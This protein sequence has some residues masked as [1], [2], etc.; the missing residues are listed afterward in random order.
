VHKT[1]SKSEHLKDTFQPRFML[2]RRTPSF[3]TNPDPYTPLPASG[4][5]QYLWGNIPTLDILRVGDNEDVVDAVN[6]S[7]KILFAA[8]GDLKNAIKT[9]VGLPEGYSGECVVVLNNM[10]FI[11]VARNAIMLLIAMHLD[12]RSQ[13]Q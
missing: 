7:F 2:Q 12:P 13:C 4:S 8:S 6:R 5:A 10:E 3:W 1:T 11:I 9:I